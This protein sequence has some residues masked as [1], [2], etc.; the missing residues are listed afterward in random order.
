MPASCGLIS[1]V[2]TSNLDP[3]FV[4]NRIFSPSLT[5]SLVLE[6]NRNLAIYSLG[7]QQRWSTNT[8]VLNPDFA[9]LELRLTGD[10]FW[11]YLGYSE[12]R[13]PETFSSFQYGVSYTSNGG[14]ANGPY[15]L[16]MGDDGI[17][18][19]VNLFGNEAWVSTV[20]DSP[21][22]PSPEPAAPPLPPSPPPSPPSPL[23]PS[24]P[25]QPPSP[26]PPPPGGFAL[27]RVSSCGEV[28]VSQTV[29]ALVAWPAAM[30]CRSAP[31]TSR[32]RPGMHV[33]AA[34][35]F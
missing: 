13:Q 23:P 26:A 20:L 11:F 28:D 14:R 22:P 34:V 32:H 19:I 30:V 8:G 35:S 25:P 17:A 5:Y 29:S 10:G 31:V 21:P 1:T 15:R 24:P 18:R 2:S 12:G 4:C 7:S 6:N 3:I 33:R 9:D 16:L 27:L